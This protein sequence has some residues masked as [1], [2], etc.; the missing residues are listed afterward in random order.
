M[1]IPAA[2][3]GSPPGAAVWKKILNSLRGLLAWV[4]AGS[5]GQT[6]CKT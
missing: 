6:R 5:K 4:A 1:K 3:P 2:P